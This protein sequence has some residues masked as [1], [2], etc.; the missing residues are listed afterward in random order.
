MNLI[1]HQWPDSLKSKEVDEVFKI[2]L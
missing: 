2:W 1:D